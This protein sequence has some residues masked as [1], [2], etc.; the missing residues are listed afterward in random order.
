M[1]SL[2]ILF[3]ILLGY[4]LFRSKFLI[5]LAKQ[6]NKKT[7]FETLVFISFISRLGLTILLL[8]I[9][10]FIIGIIV[11]GMGNKVSSGGFAPFIIIPLFFFLS[12]LIWK[13]K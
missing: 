8:A 12:R 11:Q 4:W 1:F 3:I 6:D 7:N 10:V 9:C 5:K 13:V 2:V